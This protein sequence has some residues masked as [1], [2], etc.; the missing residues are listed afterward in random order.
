MQRQKQEGFPEFKASMNSAE[1][2]KPTGKQRE[3]HV[4]QPTNEQNKNQQEQQ[5][6][7]KYRR[8]EK[9]ICCSY[10][11]KIEKD[12]AVETRD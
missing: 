1:H 2:T 6:Y 11:M 3:T 7:S 9:A 8:V 10:K 12:M 4:N 5:N